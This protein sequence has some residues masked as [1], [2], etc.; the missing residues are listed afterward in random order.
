MEVMTYEELKRSDKQDLKV[1][2]TVINN[3]FGEVLKDIAL[4]K[5]WKVAKS[6]G[7]TPAY[8]SIIITTIKAI[9]GL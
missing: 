8:L 7:I 4:N 2:A 6:L 5:Q 1:V 9:R 3:E